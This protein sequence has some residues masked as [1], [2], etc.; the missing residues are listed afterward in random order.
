MIGLI[1]KKVGMT[2]VFDERGVVT[3]VT[4]IEVEPNL[5]LSERTPESDGYNARVLATGKVEE[6]SVTKPYRG[7]FGDFAPRAHM[8]EFRD[9]GPDCTKGDELDVSLFSEALFVDVTG[10]SKGKGFQG[11]MKRHNFGGG[12]ATH[13]SKFKREA[14]ATGMAATPSRVHK[15]TKMAG[16]M[17]HDR[18]TVHNLRVMKVDTEK[19]VILVKGPVPGP[20][21]STILVTDAKKKN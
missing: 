12:R 10:M 21:N 19:Q 11:V 5:V 18:R 16:R 2:Q 8:V 4:V 1:G 3:P 7:Q 14:G 15:G 20:R 9:F 6:K 13:G 17:G